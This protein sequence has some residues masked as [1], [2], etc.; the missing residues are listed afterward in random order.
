MSTKI[1]DIASLLK[2]KGDI[3]GTVFIVKTDKAKM[4]M[5][6]REHNE[7]LE[8]HRYYICFSK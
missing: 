4:I 5:T 7:V 2:R 8:V 6:S 1:D 3:F